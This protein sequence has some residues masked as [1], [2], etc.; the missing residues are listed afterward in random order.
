MLRKH[1]RYFSDGAFSS[2]HL[3]LLNLHI[4]LVNFGQILRLSVSA[5][6]FLTLG[7]SLAATCLAMG[8]LI[9]LR[10]LMLAVFPACLW[11]LYIYVRY[12]PKPE[13]RPS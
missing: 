11:C 5:V 12:A 13:T 3:N 7:M 8:A 4:G 10:W 2:R 9:G 1:L 6:F